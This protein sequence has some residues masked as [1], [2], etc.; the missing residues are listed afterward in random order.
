MKFFVLLELLAVGVLG[1]AVPRSAEPPSVSPRAAC[2]NTA[3]NRQCWGDYDINTDWY[4]VT[5]DTG[6]TR[7]YWLEAQNIT[8]APDGYQRQVLCFNGTVP[9]PL[10]EANWGDWIVIHFTNSMQDNGTAIH[11]HGMHQA[12]TIGADG[13]PGVTQCPIAPGDTMTY[14]FRATQYGTAWYHSHF[15]L[16][17]AEG[18]VGPI[19]IH[20]PTT[21]N[22]D[23]DLGNFMLQD[24]GH[25]SA[26][27][28]WIATQ[29]KIALLQPAAENGL[30]NGKN[31]YTCDASADAKCVGGAERLVTTVTKGQKYLLRIIGA[32]VD[33]WF[34][35]AIDGHTFRVVAADLVPIIPYSTNN[36]ILASGQRYDIIVEANQTVGNYWLRAIYQT[37]CNQ[38]NNDNKDN[39]LGVF[40][41]DG[42]ASTDPTTTVASSITNSCGDEPYAS[43]VPWVSK[44]VGS[45]TI[46]D[47]VALSWYYQLDL[48]FKWTLHSKTLVVNW[49]DP[50]TRS[51]YNNDL[52][53]PDT[54]N[55][56]QV[57]QSNAWTYWII[58]DLTLVGA[59]HPMHLH[60]HDF[61]IL[62]Q[63]SGL[64]TPFVKLNT[65]NP[66]RRDTATLYGNGYTVIAFQT[67]NPGSWLLHC[68]I[69]WHASQ[70]LAMQLI[71][72]EG[73]IA[74]IVGQDIEQYERV[75]KNWNS[76]HGP[77]EMDDSG[78]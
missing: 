27:H 74:P 25:D 24:W 34:K 11:W 60:G 29:Q 23:V 44:E 18:L 28:I 54:S 56:Y 1:H 69:A 33:G 36:I 30:I 77:Y 16:Q 5:P 65:K 58:Q 49:S 75:C 67:D 66:P 45:A 3:S 76:W 64:Y 63:G 59:Y 12:G 8:L 10:I 22:Y 17:L 7:E 19:I 47:A 43:L 57:S 41:Y 38:N 51:I 46:T 14:R 53:F 71:E 42:A 48:V 70:G 72:R 39:I 6:V 50:T 21:A 40:R 35:F 55:V 61:Y 62:A 4:S 26:F 78:I 32:Q 20:G 9:G 37:G 2:E 13:V 15:S 73:E 52:S 68:H 31:P